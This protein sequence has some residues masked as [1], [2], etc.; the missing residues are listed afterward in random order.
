MSN[1]SVIA[2]QDAGPAEGAYIYAL[3]QVVA[4][5]PGLSIEK[6]FTQVASRS[7]TDGQTDR[8]ILHA[9]LSLKSNRYI[10]RQMCWVLTV[11]NFDAYVLQP[12]D[13]ADFELLVESLRP[14]PSPLDMDVVIG[15]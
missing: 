15:R 9:V 14:A 8:E 4:R 13:P 2:Q 12:R 3:G 1:E 5:F 11:Q 6:E 7:A 10:A